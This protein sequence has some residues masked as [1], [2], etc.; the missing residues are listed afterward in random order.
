RNLLRFVILLLLQVFVLDNVHLGGYIN[1]YLYIL[2][3]LLLPFE[4]P[5]WLLLTS[6]FLLGFG[7]DMFSGTGGIHAA[8][9][10]LM[11]FM[12]PFTLTFIASRREYEPGINPTIADLGLRW[13][14]SYA[15]LLTLIH[16]LALFMLEMFSFAGFFDTL[17]RAFLS[18]LVTFSLILVVQYLF[19]PVRSSRS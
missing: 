15:G 8:A 5:G 11:A 4:T 3:L 6:A 9:I 19:Y 12:R 10:T 18:T 14:V 7:V 17:R 1:P 2:F 16:H 13:F